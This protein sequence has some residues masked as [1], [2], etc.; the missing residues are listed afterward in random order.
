MYDLSYLTWPFFEQRHADLARNV[1]AWAEANTPK[2]TNG[3]G[4]DAICQKLVAALG[5]EHLLETA[6]PAEGKFD[7][8][9]ICLT[10]EILAYHSALSDFSYAMQGLGTASI[11]IFGSDAQK[12]KWL[13]GA[14]RG[15]RVAAFALS[16]SEAGSDVSAMSTELT[17][18]A[19]GLRLHGCKTWISNGGIADQYV[20][21]AKDGDRHT[22]ILVSS[23]DG[24]FSVADRIDIMSPHPLATIKFDTCSIA[25]EAILGGRGNGLRIALGTLDVFRPSVGAAA[26]GLARRAFSEALERASARR[27]FGGTLADLQITQ[28]KLADMALKIDASALLVYRAAWMR[29]VA[30]A[31]RITREAAMAKLYATEAAQ[32]VIDDAVQIW[33]AAGVRTGSTVERLYRDIRAMRIYEGASEVQRLVI[34]K[35]VLKGQ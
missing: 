29:D 17:E 34:A 30:G 35:S 19:E 27:M 20:I 28:A 14:R 5:R 8:R 2:L 3:E 9:S 11:S 23:K 15:D 24:G 26:L 1:G 10:R 7:L 6:I 18:A 25:P 4:V 13:P 22:A 12:A 33:G 16:E 31:Q 21:F 32:E